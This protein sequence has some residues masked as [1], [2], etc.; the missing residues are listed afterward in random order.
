MDYKTQAF[1]DRLDKLDFSRMY[2]GD[3]FLTWEKTDD[4]IE[5]VFTIA[6]A[7]RPRSCDRPLYSVYSLWIRALS[8]ISPSYSSKTMRRMRQSF[9]SA[10][11][12]G[13]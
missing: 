12:G 13:K 3:F 10:E 9:A 1:I 11:A 7:L 2:G 5:A 6:D 8:F 4:E